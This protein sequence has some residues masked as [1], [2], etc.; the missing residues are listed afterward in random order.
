MDHHATT[1]VDPRVLQAMLPHFGPDFGNASSRS[2]AF[3]WRAQEAV[4][5]ARSQVGHL[6]GAT[7]PSKE[8]VFASGAT[9]SDN[10][11]IKGVMRQSMA[12]GRGDHLITVC[13]EHKA[14]VDSARRMEREGAS[15]TW[16]SVNEQGLI[17]LDE[18]RDALTD[19][20]ALVSVMLANNETGCIQPI[21]AIAELAHERGAL[22][23]CDATQGVG[24]IAFSVEENGVDLVSFTAHKIYGPKGV[25]ALYV[26][27]SGARRVRL[28]ADLDGGGQERGLRSGTLN[29]PG[30]V[31]FGAA[32]E[33][34]SQEGVAESVSV[35]RLRDH[36]YGRL[37]EGLGDVWLNGPTLDNR[38]A[39][40]LN[41]SFPH[42][43]GESLILAL[44]QRVAVSSG[45]A[46]T[47]SSME[48]SY[49]LRAM[50]LSKDRADGSVRFGLGRGHTQADVDS[51]ANYTIEQV[52][53]LRELSV[54][55][56]MEQRGEDPAEIDW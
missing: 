22:M 25:G 14:V 31:G 34:M 36:L 20:T 27:R 1:P 41:V 2:H 12:E 52:Q 3:G 13:T 51:V 49:V 23:H 6:I 28:M 50:G 10:L 38:L 24:R 39:G 45:A 42:I 37:S 54:S 32:C 9:E 48:P 46:C 5:K 43:D 16:L 17:D 18:L 35:G 26:R 47:S 19:Q 8:I 56:R 30:I 40:N 15:V 33:L 53:R 11:A 7:L 29:V 4:E 55:W 44:Q 21:R